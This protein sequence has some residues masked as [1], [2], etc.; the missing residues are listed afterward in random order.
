MPSPSILHHSG[1]L[2]RQQG[3]VLVQFA[4]LALILLTI[5]GVVQIGHMYSAKRDLQRIADLAALE[6]VN[7]FKAATVCTDAKAAGAKSISKQWPPEVTAQGPYP[8]MVECGNWNKERGFLPGLGANGVFNAARVTL[9]GETLKL[10]PFTGSRVVRAMATAAI[11]DDPVATFSVGAGVVRLNEGLLNGLLS[12]LL[13]TKIELSAVD[14]EGLANTKVNLLWMKEALNL[15]AGTYDELLGTTID[16]KSLLRASIEAARRSG[17]NTADVGINALETLLGLTLPVHLDGLMINLL[18]DTKNGISG[19]LELGIESGGELTG[20]NADTSLLDILMVGLQVANKDSAVNIPGTVLNLK[21]LAD[22]EVK[23]KI[24]EPPTIA[25]GRAGKNASGQYIT[26][27]HNGQVRVFIK[28]NVLSALG[29]GN[30]LLDLNLLLVHLK[31]SLPAGQLLELPVNLEVGSADARLEEIMCHVKP[32]THKA[33]IGAK[34]GLAYVSLAD[35]PEAMTNAT[36]PWSALD[37]QRFNLLNLQVRATILL[38]L[39]E[40]LNAPVKL[41]ARLNA[42]IENASN[43]QL[44]EFEYATDKPYADQLQEDQARPENSRLLTKSV[45][46]RQQI[47]KSIANALTPS[48]LDVDIDTSGLRLLGIKL[49]LLSDIVDGL[50]NNVLAIV[51]ALLPILKALLNPVFALLDSVLGPLLELLGVQIGYAD[52]Q[53]KDI[54]CSP[55]MLVD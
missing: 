45:G 53:L 49:D 26:T 19:L 18:K 42:P 31:V 37:K 28:L 47:G 1:T 21:P 20:L 7:G 8:D 48:L 14:Y 32:N 30:T 39:V 23:V 15:S 40:V 34:P 41:L 44:L 4:L 6:S 27:A 50:L 2:A 43:Y 55:A 33:R 25:S 29:G 54:N 5:L 9:T 36:K 38:D 12:S 51:S 22:A 11:P 13:G 16:M 10:V 35:M 3:A 17:D 24:I 46:S 52:V